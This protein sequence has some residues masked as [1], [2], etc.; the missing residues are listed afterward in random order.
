MARQK[1]HR[2]ARKALLDVRKMI[3]AL[4]KKDGSEAETRKNIYY[5][6]ETLMGYDIYK[7]VTSEYAIYAAGETVHCD[8]AIEFDRKEASG[9]ARSWRRLLQGSEREIDN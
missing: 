9:R 3:E 4:A 1:L 7:H 8:I 2:E 6:F 5:I